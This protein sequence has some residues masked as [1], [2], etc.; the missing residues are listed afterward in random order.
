MS[1]PSK[2]YVVWSLADEAAVVSNYKLQVSVLGKK[3]S[4]STWAGLVDAKLKG[5]VDVRTKAK[6]TVP[7]DGF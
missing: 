3:A 5:F 7:K 6:N 4:T 2:T 1:C